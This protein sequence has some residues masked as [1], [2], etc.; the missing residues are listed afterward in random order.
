LGNE[1]CVELLTS[2]LGKYVDNV[3]NDISNES[4]YEIDVEGKCKEEIIDYCVGAL[5]NL[6]FDCDDNK[7]RIKNTSPNLI[8]LVTTIFTIYINSKKSS[9]NVIETLMRLIIAITSNH[10]INRQ[11]ILTNDKNPLPLVVKAMRRYDK[12]EDIVRTACEVFIQLHYITEDQRNE[13]LQK[14]LI[15]DQ[16]RVVNLIS[17]DDDTIEKVITLWNLDNIDSQQG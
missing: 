15:D 8:T 14:G 5:F 11:S 10:L 3:S 2:L 16:I 17:N 9:R 6:M 12:D 1:G 7:N 4:I 13:L